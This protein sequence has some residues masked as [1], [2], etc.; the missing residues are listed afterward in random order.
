[1]KQQGYF[2]LL[3]K[4]EFCE[5]LQKQDV[6]RS[7]SKLQ[8][9]HTWKPNYITR[10]V[11]NGIG[12]QDTFTCLEGMRNTH[13]A[14]GWAMTGQHITVLE[15][16]QIGISLDRT[17]N[18]I[19]AGIKGANS[20]GIAIEIVGNFDSGGDTMTTAQRQTVTHLYACLC[21]RFSIPI[22]TDHIVYHSWYTAKGERLPDYMNSKSS[23][24]CPGTSFWG[25]G[26]TIGSAEKGF[27]VDVQREYDHLKGN[28]NI[29]E[30]E[31]MTL[32]IKRAFVELQEEVQKLKKKA[33]LDSIPSYA[34]EAV[35]ALIKLKDKKGNAVVDTPNGRSADFYAV[36]T[37]LYRAGLFDK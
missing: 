26:N 7:I 27:L 31:E 24:T 14:A 34:K 16:G 33:S 19:P 21:D 8:V 30:N 25:L 5:W 32:E 36:V 3:D 20:G 15:T 13:L 18:R 12:Q 22:N 28:N 11:V 9:H 2:L 10:K 35:E 37:V 23:K 29:E 4:S 17:L 1:M 6:T